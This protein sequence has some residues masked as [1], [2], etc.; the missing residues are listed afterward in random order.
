MDIDGGYLVG[1]GYLW[2]FKKT[3]GRAE[4]G[5]PA[6]LLLFLA[7]PISCCFDSLLL[8]ISCVFY[9]PVSVALLLWVQT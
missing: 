8:A 7:S 5:S 3:G 6:T 9:C 4:E 2:R 1:S